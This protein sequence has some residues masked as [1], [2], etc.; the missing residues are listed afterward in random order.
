MENKYPMLNKLREV[1][2]Q[3]EIC[4]DFLRWLMG[5]YTLFRTGEVRDEPFYMGAG[6]YIDVEKTLAEY[7]GIDLAEVE[8][9]KEAMLC[10]FLAK[11][12]EG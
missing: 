10:E 2:G 12:K 11:E 3:S 6:D 4:G 7:F 8:K 5:K 1:Q 9:E